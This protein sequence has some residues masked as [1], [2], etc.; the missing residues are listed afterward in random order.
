MRGL[1]TSRLISLGAVAW[2]GISAPASGQERGSA[3]SWTVDGLGECPTEEEVRADLERILLRPLS[4]AAAMGTHASVEVARAGDAMIRA[5]VR[6]SGEPEPR[7]LEAPSCRAVADGVLVVVA[8]AID[9]ASLVRARAERP[10]ER[11]AEVLSTPAPRAP[12]ARPRS[13]AP[14]PVDPMRF[15]VFAAGSLDVG[16]LP[17][18]G[19][20]GSL[21]AFLEIGRWQLEARLR[22]ALPREQRLADSP[23]LGGSFD[24][25]DVAAFICLEAARA[26]A[27]SLRACAQAEGGSISGQGIGSSRVQEGGALWLAV[28]LAPALALALGDHVRLVLRGEAVVALTRASF[29][30]RPIG[31]VHESGPGDLRVGLGPEVRF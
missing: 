5:S 18:A 12:Q 28:G 16:A 29:V 7:V 2:L 17:G 21:G 9:P 3:L 31:A 26:G 13:A 19:L 30:I 1:S 11:I 20:D 10:Q 25:V 4:E 22:Y 23:A 15:G 24:L 14:P 6:L 8:Y 27:L